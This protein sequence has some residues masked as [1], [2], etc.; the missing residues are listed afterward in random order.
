MSTKLHERTFLESNTGAK[1]CRRSMLGKPSTKADPLTN[2]WSLRHC[3]RSSARRAL[4]MPDILVQSRWIEFEV[5]RRSRPIFRSPAGAICL[6]S[7]VSH[8]RTQRPLRGG[9]NAMRHD[10]KHQMGSFYLPYDSFSGCRQ[11]NGR[12]RRTAPSINFLL[13]RTYSPRAVFALDRVATLTH[14]ATHAP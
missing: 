11:H 9:P 1:A 12:E 10:E 7:G 6:V 4:Q 3:L 14:A 2:G 5:N 13:L 8:R